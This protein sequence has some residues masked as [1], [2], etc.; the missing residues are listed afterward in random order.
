VLSVWKLRKNGVIV[1]EHLGY[2]DA[3]HVEARTVR[4]CI[5]AWLTDH[6]CKKDFYTWYMSVPNPTYIHYLQQPRF[7]RMD[8]DL[9]IGILEKE[10]VIEHGSYERKIY[11]DKWTFEESLSYQED[12]LLRKR[13]N[14][15][16]AWSFPESIEGFISDWSRPISSTSAIKAASEHLTGWLESNDI[17]E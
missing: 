4:D 5:P 17:R 9:I 1:K 11:G 15:R 3:I 7:D 13:E 16:E 6:P 2:N 12:R 8:E 14:R 10:N